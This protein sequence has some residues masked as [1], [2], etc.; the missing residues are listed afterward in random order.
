MSVGG[1]SELAFSPCIQE[2]PGRDHAAFQGGFGVKIA[3][4]T[5]ILT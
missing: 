4:K 3:A 5:D 2:I 1:G